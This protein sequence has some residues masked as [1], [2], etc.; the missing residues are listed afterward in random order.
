MKPYLAVTAAILVAFS[1]CATGGKPLKESNTEQNHQLVIAFENLDLE[2][3]ETPRGVAI[4]FPEVLLF[5]F[6][7][8]RMTIGARA[9]MRQIA[10]VVNVPRYQFRHIAV[11]GHTDAVGS[12]KYNLALSRGRAESVARALVFSEVQKERITVHAFGETRPLAP[13]KHPDG[14]DNPEGR[15]RNRRVELYIENDT[16][17]P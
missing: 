6:D 10:A 5:D 8:A 2:V 14:T 17:L 3:K 4:F 13:N 9:K 1:G 7:S 15:R 12:E 16:Q 11:E